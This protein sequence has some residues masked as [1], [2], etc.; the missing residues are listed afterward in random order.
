MK[1]NSI[2]KFCS[3]HRITCTLSVILITTCVCSVFFVQAVFGQTTFKQM[4]ETIKLSEVFSAEKKDSADSVNAD[5]TGLTTE[6]QQPVTPSAAHISQTS[7]ALTPS[8]SVETADAELT[9]TPSPAAETQDI[10]PPTSEATQSD[11][12]TKVSTD[13][14]AAK[15]T[16]AP[17]ATAKATAAPAAT[18]PAAT[19]PAATQPAATTAA[20]AAAA[21]SLDTPMA[22]AVLDLTNQ[23]RA[24]ALSWNDTLAE[25][26]QTRAKELVISFSH[27][28]PDGSDCWM[29]DCQ[30][31]ENLARGHCSA[32]DV[33]AHWMSSSTHAANI[34]NESYTQMGVGCY[35]SNGVYYW[36]QEFG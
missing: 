16:A 25:I 11:K 1:L 18:Q 20:P 5:E 10:A 28:R 27:D 26:A 24:S 31:A 3:R 35:Y 36:A 23:Q 6:L 21:G 29:A 8:P 33:V 13:E 4:F 15:A 22:Y 2:L 9:L 32:A 12:N 19:Q 30:L 34:T 17:A 7:L 14:T